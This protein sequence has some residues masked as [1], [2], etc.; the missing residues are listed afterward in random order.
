MAF[1][2][3]ETKF[4]GPTNCRGARIKAQAMDLWSDGKRE[5]VTV[6]YDYALNSEDNHTADAMHLLPKICNTPSDYL[7]V[8]GA[9]ERGYV[10]VVA[11][12]Q[13]IHHPLSALLPI[14]TGKHVPS[15][16]L[17]TIELHN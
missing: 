1:M 6:G 9:T 14:V 2:A 15:G 7:L 8:V 10:F 4:L 16:R 3:I 13:R 12:V 17:D 11:S 5:S